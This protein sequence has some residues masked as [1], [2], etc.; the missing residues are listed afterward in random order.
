MEHVTSYYM[1]TYYTEFNNVI[2][3]VD[4]VYLS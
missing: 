4:E 2:T 3:C 1:L